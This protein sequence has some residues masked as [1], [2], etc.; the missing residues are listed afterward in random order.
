MLFRFN[1]RKFFW[2]DYCLQE[3]IKYLRV[4]GNI[5]TVKKNM[6]GAIG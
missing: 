3:I 1:M 5:S 2:L 6:P 4:G